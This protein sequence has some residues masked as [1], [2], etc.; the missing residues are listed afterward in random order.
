MNDYWQAQRDYYKEREWYLE[1]AKDIRRGGDGKR[2]IPLKYLSKTLQEW[3]K[4]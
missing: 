1:R 4:L 3:L 2:R